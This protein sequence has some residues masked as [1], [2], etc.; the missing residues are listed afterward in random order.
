[1]RVSKKQ[2]RF[3]LPGHNEQ[4]GLAALFFSRIQSFLSVKGHRLNMILWY[5]GVVNENVYIFH[6]ILHKCVIN[7]S[8]SFKSLHLN[9][10]E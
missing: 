3:C 5:G 9:G 4:F 1:M 8:K 6:A 10:G 7:L 2:K